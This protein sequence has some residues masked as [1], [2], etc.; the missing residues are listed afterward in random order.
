M[1]LIDQVV[2]TREEELPLRKWLRSFYKLD[3]H[4]TNEKIFTESMILK[5]LKLEMEDRKR[6]N[7]LIRLFSRYNAMRKKRQW[8]ELCDKMEVKIAYAGVRH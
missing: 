2:I 1:S 3:A 6:K 8:N 7:V 5:L 4:L